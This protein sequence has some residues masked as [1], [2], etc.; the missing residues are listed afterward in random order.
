[1]RF[2]FRGYHLAPTSTIASQAR[3][4]LSR[5]GSPA[6]WGVISI[7]LSWALTTTNVACLTGQRAWIPVATTPSVQAA[8]LASLRAGESPAMKT[9][10]S[11]ATKSRTKL[12][13]RWRCQRRPRRRRPLRRRLRPR[14]RRLRRPRR[15][16][17]RRRPHRRHPR[18]RLRSRRRLSLRR[19]LTSAA[20][21]PLAL[22]G[23]RVAAASH[24][25]LLEMRPPPQKPLSIM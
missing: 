3:A 8:L 11:V 14:R 22:A 18:H 1:M 10:G 20:A 23:R 25:L 4:L 16:P 24:S 19:S 2:R 9:W 15:R 7:R 5:A 17:R 21:S 12:P 6:G 13:V